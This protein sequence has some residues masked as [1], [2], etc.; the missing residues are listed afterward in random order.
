MAIC[1]LSSENK[2]YKNKQLSTEAHFV[3]LTFGDDQYYS[4]NIETDR[5]LI[6]EKVSSDVEHLYPQA[7]GIFNKTDVVKNI[8]YQIKIWFYSRRSE[9]IPNCECEPHKCQR[10][11][12]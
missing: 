5:L 1:R 6:P 11:R 10:R 8:E 12:V 7:T 9:E 4:L 3:A 2:Y